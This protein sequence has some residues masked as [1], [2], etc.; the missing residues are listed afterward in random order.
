MNRPQKIISGGQT[1]A[2]RGALDFAIAHGIEHGGSCPHG[3]KAEDG[4][5]PTR[6][7]LQEL[8]SAE[9]P[10]RT[11]RN[12]EDAD[13]TVIFVQAGR[14][15]SRGTALTV[16]CAKA[17]ARPYVVLHDFPDAS[18]DAAALTD[19]LSELQPGVLNV[20]GNRESKTPGMHAYVVRVLG[21][22]WD[23]KEQNAVVGPYPTASAAL[24]LWHRD[25]YPIIDF[26][27]LWTLDSSYP[28][29]TASSTG[30]NTL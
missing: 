6:Y 20:A 5:I 22:V 3:R 21:A 9:Y 15:T 25:P 8:A 14:I 28:S 7:K 19:F 30:G 11:K 18:A 16:R 2:D 29:S 26:R 17:A 10:P 13:A 23:A 4:P 1:G 27:A 12:V 24:H